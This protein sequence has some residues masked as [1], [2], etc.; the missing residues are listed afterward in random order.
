MNPI[1]EFIELLQVKDEKVISKI[2]ELG[3][4]RRYKKGDIILSEGEY[5]EFVPFLLSGIARGF[6]ID[7]HGKE[8]T[9]CLVTRRMEN[10]LPSAAIDGIAFKSVEALTDLEV[11]C[12]HAKEFLDLI[13][14][15]QSLLLCYVRLMQAVLVFQFE[16]KNMLCTLTAM[17]RYK[18]FLQT[19]PGLDKKISDKYIASYL[20][21]TPVSIS[22]LRSALR[23]EQSE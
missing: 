7:Y 5:P 2:R 4:I 19:Y 8:F 10:M 3:E 13:V 1:E 23:E 18:W 12:F 9:N 11:L 21:M 14:S 15:S 17:E 16:F 6:S 20:N 22:R